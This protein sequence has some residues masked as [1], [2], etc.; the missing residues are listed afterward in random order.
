M[1]IQALA[2]VLCLIAVGCKKEVNILAPAESQPKMPVPVVGVSSVQTNISSATLKL[3][4]SVR[5]IATV[6][7][8]VASSNFN[9]S[10]FWSS[11]NP[12]IVTVNGAGVAK[13]VAVGSAQIR[14]RAVAD[15]TKFATVTVGVAK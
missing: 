5:V 12:L 1:R 8:T 15:T 9:G 7:P 3:G 2:F 6:V 14:A 4:D 13:G 10:V 11:S